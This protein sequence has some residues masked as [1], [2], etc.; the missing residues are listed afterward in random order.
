MRNFACVV[1]SFAVALCAKNLMNNGDL[2]Y[3]DGGWY[4]WNNP[5]DKAQIEQALAAPGLGVN[6]SQGAKVTVKKRPKTWWSLQLQ[7]PPFLADSAYY[8]LEFKAKGDGP[9]NAVV[10]GGR[11]DWRQKAVASFE[12]TKEWKTFKMKFLADEKGYGLNNVIFQLGYVKGDV[13]IDDVKVTPAEPVDYEIW[14]ANAEARIDSVRKKDFEV[15]ANPGDTVKVELVRHSFPFGTALALNFGSDSLRVWYEATANKYFWAGVPENQFK[16]PDYEP[17]KGKIRRKEFRQYLDFAKK[18]GWDFRAH[19]LVWGIQDWNFDKH[20]SIQGS[21]KEI[22]KNIKERITRDLKEYAGQIP[23]YD[24]WNEPFHEPF[25][26]EKC[27]WDLL[28]SSFVWAHRADSSA[29]LYIN[30]FNVVALGETDRYY[31]LVKGLL[32]RKIPVSGIGVQCHFNTQ[33]V[34][35]ELIRERLDRL[36][37]LGLP[38]KV[39]EFD[40]GSWDSGLGMSEEE[41]AAQYEKFL[42]SAFSH[43]AVVGIMLWGFWD[44]RHWLKNGGIVAADGREK[45]AAK[46]VYKLWHET[47]TTKQAVVAGKDG[48]ATFRGFPGT[49]KVTVRGVTREMDFK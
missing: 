41:Q 19:T 35:P 17:K 9:I 15:K 37:E 4:V 3:G 18:Y 28:D 29:R 22:R 25:L 44:S 49:Y 21:C 5:D 36:A 13:F 11:P 33:R 40:M 24:V 30:E 38:I 1:L 27:G 20:W 45:P 10:Q 46:T 48:K 12:L 7:A 14:Y 8:E 6:G 32:D 43:K 34:E 31:D 16:W 2:E 42:R 23:E 47:W 26:F 39:T